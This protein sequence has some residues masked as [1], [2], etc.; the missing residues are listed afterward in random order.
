MKLQTPNPIA[1]PGLEELAAAWRRQLRDL[2]DELL[3]SELHDAHDARRSIVLNASNAAARVLTDLHAQARAIA[4]QASINSGDDARNQNNEARSLLAL[5]DGAGR[6]I[7][8]LQRAPDQRFTVSPSM[9]ANAGQSG[10][11][12]LRQALH[13]E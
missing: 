7:A 2:K 6:T 10:V 8:A 12:Q 3:R 5:F 13:E 1:D 11:D 9:P 4:N